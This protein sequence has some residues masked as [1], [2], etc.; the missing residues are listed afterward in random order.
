MAVLVQLTLPSISG[1]DLSGLD[2]YRWH[3]SHERVTLHKC[4][5]VLLLSDQWLLYRCTVNWHMNSLGV[6]GHLQICAG[7]CLSCW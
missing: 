5:S 3:P 1:L 4:A 7:S 2:A 6:V